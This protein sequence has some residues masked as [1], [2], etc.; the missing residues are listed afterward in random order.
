MPDF[1]SANGQADGP[2]KKGQHTPAHRYLE[3]YLLFR[4]GFRQTK[5]G[6]VWEKDGVSYGKEAALQKAQQLRH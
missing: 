6:L 1:T 5:P 4:A 2:Q 3:N